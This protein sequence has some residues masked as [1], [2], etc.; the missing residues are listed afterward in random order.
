MNHKKR[1]LGLLENLLYYADNGSCVGI[2]STKI[3]GNLTADV[4]KKALETTQK[5]EILLRT[6]VTLINNELFYTSD[7]DHPLNI[8]KIKKNIAIHSQDI[9]QSE[10]KFKATPDAPLWKVI[11]L[12]DH[13][14][15]RVHE[16]A[17]ICHHVLMDG[18][19]GTLMLQEIL[20]VCN[21]ITNNETI[22]IEGNNQ[23]P[24]SIEES[25]YR[26]MKYKDLVSGALLTFKEAFKLISCFKKRDYLGITNININTQESEKAIHMKY[27]FRSWNEHEV[28]TLI[29]TSKENKVTMHAAFCA[30][31]FMVLDQILDHKKNILGISNFDMRPFFAN[32]QQLSQLLGFTASSRAIHTMKKGF[33]NANFWEVARQCQDLLK[34]NMDKSYR[35]IGFLKLLNTLFGN[36][37]KSTKDYPA[38]IQISNFE[39]QQIQPPTTHFSLDEV[40]AY[41]PNCTNDSGLFLF[42]IVMFRGK[43]FLTFG[44]LSPVISDK[45]AS[46]YLDKVLQMLKDQ[47]K[48]I[49]ESR[50]NL[51]IL[52]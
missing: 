19:A 36:I 5:K 11:L 33:R 12:V 46:E 28:N 13:I 34:E 50:S 43:M 48:H 40:W 1:K 3:K 29:Q 9:F 41:L 22:K 16:L 15:E 44:Y 18:K 38:D 52:A 47:A 21:N 25:C 30:A 42:W 32:R 39:V 10:S 23:F 35:L 4:I 49:P 17:F 7:D 31:S 45:F 20:T 37:L 26:N 27:L 14:S 2:L 51:Q 6:K 8:K 24:P